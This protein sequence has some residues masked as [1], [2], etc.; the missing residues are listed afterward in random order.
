MSEARGARDPAKPGV[1][2]VA[3]CAP[4]DMAEV[5]ALFEE[6]ADWLQVDLCFQGF[7]AELASLPGRYAPPEGGLWFAKVEGETAGIVGL[8]PLDAAPGE[9]GVCELKRLWIRTPYRGLGL[10][11]RLTETALEA[12][13]AA[14]YARICLDTL[15]MMGEAQALYRSLGFV[16]I[17]AYY[18]NPEDGVMYLERRL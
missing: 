16:E 2:I 14:G 15:P 12:A 8:R 3:A 4:G 9:T 11:R 6:Y 5:R 1:T 7:A 13:K 10:G 17:P 18:H